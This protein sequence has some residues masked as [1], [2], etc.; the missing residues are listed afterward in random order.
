MRFRAVLDLDRPGVTVVEV[1]DVQGRV[2]GRIQVVGE[3]PD[4]EDPPEL[5]LEEARKILERPPC[6]V[7]RRRPV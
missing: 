1:L 2:R 3:I 4:L 7:R 5:V 6:Y